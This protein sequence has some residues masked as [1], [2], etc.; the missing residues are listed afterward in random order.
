MMVE[1]DPG[2]GPVR[3]ASRE[4]AEINMRSFVDDLALADVTVDG[5]GAHEGGRWTFVLTLGE[6]KSKIDMPGLLLDRVRYVKAPGQNIWDFPRLY[7]NGSS[8]VW[9]Y[10]LDRARESLTGSEDES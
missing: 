4:N 1:I 7:E 5:P 2:A 8:W 10:A 9:I 3:A 6:R